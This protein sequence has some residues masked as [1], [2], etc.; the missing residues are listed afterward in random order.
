MNAQLRAAP[1]PAS[2]LAPAESLLRL[3]DVHKTF[4]ALTG[5]T[6]VALD[7]VSIELRHG[8]ILGLI[9]SSDSGK[10][11]LGLLA[12]GLERPTAGQVALDGVDYEAGGAK[13]RRAIA[14]LGPDPDLPPTRS[15]RDI[16]V[17]RR[18]ALGA[19]A[20][21]GA[22]ERLFELLDLEGD[23]D[24]PACEL[25]AGHRRRA[26]LARALAGEPRLLILDE[27]T[28][29]LDP[30]IAGTFLTALARLNAEA[31][32]T[33]LLITHDMTAVTALASRVAVLHQ[34]RIVEEGPTARVFARP[35]HAVTRRFAAAATGATLPP[36]IAGKL[37]DTATP[38]GQ[39][40]IRL[41]FEG[42][43]ATR[44]VL[45]YVARELGF[46]LGIVAGSLGAAGG[47]PYGVL[48]VAAPSD[49]PYFTAAVERLEDAEL[50]V[51]VLGFIA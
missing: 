49:E 7:G 23:A 38:G 51:E 10:S 45:T 8:E 5:E 35:A 34:G 17:E 41:A 2:P 32:L 22:L 16:V 20:T 29:A 4:T 11:T 21:P 39:A 24:R 1:S 36:F 14:V 33:V 37:S 12:A 46:D 31:R 40:L 50:G 44:P 15:V 48:I 42:P 9:G 18:D 25:S 28:S 26:A 43:S 19:A 6:R 3:S 13:L 30:E 27:A 47:A